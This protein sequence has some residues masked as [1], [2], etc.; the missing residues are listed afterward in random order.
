[1]S[2][3]TRRK[4]FLLNREGEEQRKR[5]TSLNIIGKEVPLQKKYRPQEGSTPPPGKGEEDAEHY[6]PE[7]REDL[8]VMAV[9]KRL[10][11]FKGVQNTLRG[12]SW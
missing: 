10:S 2:G 9:A 5:K 8:V 6:F 4:S 7:G 11:T 3:S 12:D 1:V